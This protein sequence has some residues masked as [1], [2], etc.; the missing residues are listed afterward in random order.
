MVRGIE[1]LRAAGTPVLVMVRTWEFVPRVSRRIAPHVRWGGATMTLPM[2]FGYPLDVVVK[3]DVG[4]PI[5]SLSLEAVAAYHD[6]Q[7]AVDIELD[8]DRTHV[9]LRYYE[10][11]PD[12]LNVPRRFQ[13]D[14]VIIPLTLV[15]M[16]QEPDLGLEPGDMVGVHIFDLPDDDIL[17]AAEYDYH[18]VFDASE[19][20][21]LA[22]FEGRIVV[23]G[24]YRFGRD[25]V[26]HPS[27]RQP[28]GAQ[29]VACSIEGMLRGTFMRWGDAW[30]DYTPFGYGSAA[31]FGVVIAAAT[32]G[33]SRR[34]LAALAI[35]VAAMALAS[36][37]LYHQQAFVYNPTLYALALLI[38]CAMGV[39]IMQPHLSRP[40]V[41]PE[42][43]EK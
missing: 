4:D 31:L 6:P 40:H 32:R 28:Y 5:S 42:S 37:V 11:D 23:I 30:R 21:L 20:E 36:L 43:K 38:A 18:R 17:R 13:P 1:V 33:R 19:E 41:A 16:V 22:H 12:F 8:R 7:R 14:A 3:R 27:G 25:Q 29:V 34:R 35:V 10:R 9:R 24:D 15:T 39:R 2:R 26:P